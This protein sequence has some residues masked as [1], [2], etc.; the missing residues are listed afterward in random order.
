M[1]TAHSHAPHIPWRRHGSLDSH[2]QKLWAG[3]HGERTAAEREQ[4]WELLK[5]KELGEWDETDLARF[6]EYVSIDL[7]PVAAKILHDNRPP[8]YLV[9]LSDHDVIEMLK[10]RGQRAT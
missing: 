8:G 5:H 4:L 3:E 1:G 2:Q 7:I 9:E 6:L 10:G